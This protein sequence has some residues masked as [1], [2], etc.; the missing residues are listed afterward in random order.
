MLGFCWVVFGDLLDGVWEFVGWCLGV[1]WV[2]FGDLLGDAWGLLDG[3]F[4]L[5]FVGWGLR[6]SGWLCG[7]YLLVGW[8]GADWMCGEVMCVQGRG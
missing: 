6:F 7:W 2:A 5:G 4:C 8:V 1:C 3:V